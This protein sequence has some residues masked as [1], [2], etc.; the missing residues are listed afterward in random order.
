MGQNYQFSQLLL[1]PCQKCG[2]CGGGGISLF[3]SQ[4]EPRQI[5]EVKH[6]TVLHSHNWVCW[7]YHSQTC[8]PQDSSTFN[9]YS[10][11]FPNPC[12]KF[13]TLIINDFLNP[14]TV[15]F[16]LCSQRDHRLFSFFTLFLAM[17]TGV[18]TLKFFTSPTFYLLL[19]I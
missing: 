14:L 5:M 17:W 12:S 4:R 19:N 10:L 18:P 1:H 3:Y 6:T 16:D 7:S 8:P 11:G 15:T 2:G 9:N 13:P